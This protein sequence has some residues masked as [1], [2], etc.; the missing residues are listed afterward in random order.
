MRPRNC[1]NPELCPG[2]AGLPFPRPLWLQQP[3][4][5]GCPAP[6]CVGDTGGSTTAS[7]SP[8]TCLQ[9]HV[10]S[11][12][13]PGPS[14]PCLPSPIRSHRKTLPPSWPPSSL[15]WASVWQPSGHLCPLQHVHHRE[16]ASSGPEDPDQVRGHR[17]PAGG[18]E[19]ERAHEPSAGEGDHHQRAA[20]QVPAQEREHPQ[21]SVLSPPPLPRWC[22]VGSVRGHSPGFIPSRH[23]RVPGSP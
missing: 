21:V 12:R 10:L 22:W 5:C 2:P 23:S 7:S 20:G 14:S 9:P 1:P 13:R 6:V 8:H 17:A 4:C 11:W 15:P 19:A 18:R 3:C 16:A